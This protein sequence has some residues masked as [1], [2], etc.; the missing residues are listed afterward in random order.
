MTGEPPPDPAAWAWQ[1]MQSFVAA[2]SR[3]AVLRE[4]LQLGVGSGRV[5][6]LFLLREQPMTLAAL[7]DAHGVD[8]PYMTLITDRLESLGYVERRPHPDDRRKKIV[9]LTETGREAA[10]VAERILSEVP[11]ELRALDPSQLAQLTSILG[12]LGSSAAAVGG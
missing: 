1:L 12:R 7:A 8:R 6:V 11:A 9:V 3:T 10:E 4:R 2:H 5:R